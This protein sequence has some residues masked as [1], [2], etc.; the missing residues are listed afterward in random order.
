MT[1]SAL[2]FGHV[3][4]HRTEPVAH[5][6]RYAVYQTWLDLDELDTAFRGSWSWS[7]RRPALSWF[8]R[9]D[10]LGDPAVDLKTAVADLVEREAGWRPAGPIRL[11]TNLRTFGYCMNPVSFFYCYDRDGDEVE[12]V[13]AEVHNTPWGERHCYVL[14]APDQ[15]TADGKRVYHTPKEFHVSPFMDLEMSYR[16]VFSP[17]GPTLSVAMTNLVDGEPFFVAGTT[18]E[19]RE[20]TPGLLRRTLLLHPFMTARVVGRI[21]WNALLLKLKG[22]PVQDHPKHTGEPHPR[23]LHRPG[24]PGRDAGR[25]RSSHPPSPR[26]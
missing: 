7:A 20:I 26:P 19:R 9:A 8:R 23:R 5:G 21:Y 15:V 14:D 4:H 17:P 2:Y 16:W 25:A 1:A 18:L 11:L 12:A 3:S 6:F 22:V 24:P 13:V 10:H